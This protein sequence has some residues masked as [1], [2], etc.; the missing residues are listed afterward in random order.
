MDV[1]TDNILPNST[2]FFSAHKKKVA[3]ALYG[4]IMSYAGYQFYTRHWSAYPLT[5]LHKGVIATLSLGA[6][7]IGLIRRWQRNPSEETSSSS[8]PEE[9]PTAAPSPTGEVSTSSSPGNKPEETSTSSASLNQ[10]KN[11]TPLEPIV[12]NVPALGESELKAYLK[13]KIELKCLSSETSE[14]RYL[15]GKTTIILKVGDMTTEKADAVVNAAN[16]ALRGGGGIDGFIHKAAGKGLLEELKKRY[17]QGT[18]TG[19]A[20]ISEPH[21]LNPPEDPSKPK[22]PSE[23]KVKKIIHA[24]GPAGRYPAVLA[25]TYNNSLLCAKKVEGVETIAFCAI[26]T[27]IFGYEVEDATPVA[28]ATVLRYVME[29]PD[30]F[31]EVRFLIYKGDASRNYPI[32]KKWL[33]HWGEQTSSES[34]N[35]SPL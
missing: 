22:D 12:S 20:A 13:G 29:H 30:D 17:P 3:I 4:M 7:T 25:Q 15:C 1:S 18:P 31:K 27:G 32:Y 10:H 33:D 34:V 35:A 26:S 24:V 2:P 5:P 28:L 8:K 11:T 16:G 19:S 23:K 21:N 14:D 9:K 6:L